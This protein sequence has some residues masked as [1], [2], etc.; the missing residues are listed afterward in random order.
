MKDNLGIYH[1]YGHMQ[2]GYKRGGP[3]KKGEVI[4]KV[5]TTGRTTGPHLHWESGTSWDGYQLGGKFD[6]LNKY[7]RYAPFNTKPET[8]SSAEISPPAR[9]EQPSAITP[10]RKGSEVVIVD[11][12]Q[13]QQPQVLTP[14]PP[15]TQT[16]TPTISQF[17]LL[18]NLDRKS[19]RLNS[20]HVSESRMPSSA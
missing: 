14:P 8:T 16:S 7:S 12:T 9:P 15:Q 20:S 11:N 17:K 18:N 6:P 4:G 5:G 13:S 3:V 1:L 10:E 19:T 2:S